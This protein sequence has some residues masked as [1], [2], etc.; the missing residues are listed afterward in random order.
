MLALFCSPSC[1]L[2]YSENHNAECQVEADAS[3]AEDIDCAFCAER[4]YL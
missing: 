3:Y 1:L 2:K 4:A